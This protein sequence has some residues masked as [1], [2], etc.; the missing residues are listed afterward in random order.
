MGKKLAEEL[1]LP[2][3]D[4]DTLIEEAEGMKVPAVFEEKGEE[5]FRLVERH[6]LQRVLEEGQAVVLASGGGAPC[7]HHN[8]ELIKE[9]SVSIYLE[10]P[11]S[12]LA[13]RLWAEGIERRPLLRE[14]A[15]V[16]GLEKFLKEKFEW[17]IPFYKKADLYFPHHAHADLQELVK[18][19]QAGRLKQRF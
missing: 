2:F 13:E 12:V 19:I 14:C 15:D 11:F 10:V 5:H 6:C 17:R 8:M 4:L 7:F 16:D 9:K 3:Q 1:Y 18:E